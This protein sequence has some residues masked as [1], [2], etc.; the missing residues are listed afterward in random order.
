MSTAEIVTFTRESR[1]GGVR[2]VVHLDPTL[3]IPIDL[4]H[5]CSCMAGCEGKACW[6]LIEVLADETPKLSQEP[7]VLNRAKAADLARS[8]RAAKKGHRS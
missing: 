4:E 2:H 3:L 6:A 7:G 8:A 5:P 1:S